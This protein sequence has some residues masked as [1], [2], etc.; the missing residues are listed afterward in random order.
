[1]TL[2]GLKTFKVPSS[3]MSFS[4]LSRALLKLLALPP[5]L[6]RWTYSLLGALLALG[7]RFFDD[8]SLSLLKGLR[9]LL[10]F[11][12]ALLQSLPSSECS[13]N[14]GILLRIPTLPMCFSCMLSYFL[15]ALLAECFRVFSN[16][17]LCFLLHSL[18]FQGT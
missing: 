7:L 14:P 11:V 13:V 5:E 2:L 17:E 4:E 1:V 15:Y 16:S 12:D 18:S 6:V 10:S 8:F 3:S 9:H